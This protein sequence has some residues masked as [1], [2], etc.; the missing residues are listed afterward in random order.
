MD[1]VQTAPQTVILAEDEMSLYLQATSMRVWA[2]RGQTPFIRAD[3]SRQKTCFYGGLNLETGYEVIL[4]SAVMNS[5]TTAEYLE[6]LLHTYPDRPLLLFWDRAPWHYG[7]PIRRVLTAN[8][9]L[10]VIYFP[11]ASPELNPQEHVWKSARGAVSHNHAMN[12]L[13]EL[14]AT[15]ESHLSSNHFESSLLDHY[16]YTDLCPVFI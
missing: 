6:L 5:L 13:P 10:E 11:V 14:A 12:R 16:G 8:P 3:P 7:A 2:P 1:V 15:M 9:R 4:Q